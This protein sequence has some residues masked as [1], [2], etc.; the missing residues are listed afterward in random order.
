M[1]E[2]TT[3]FEPIEKIQIKSIRALNPD[4][5]KMLNL[6]VYCFI[7]LLSLQAKNLELILRVSLFME[8]YVNRSSPAP[9]HFP[10]RRVVKSRF[11][12]DAREPKTTRTFCGCPLFVSHAGYF[13]TK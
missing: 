13:S 4:F 3:K 8:H 5:G 10:L 9:I 2:P 6:M 1:G 11:A 12:A 7:I